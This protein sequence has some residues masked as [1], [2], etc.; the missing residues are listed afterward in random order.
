MHYSHQL[1]SLV[2]SHPSLLNPKQDGHTKDTGQDSEQGA[3]TSSDFE[4]IAFGFEASSLEAGQE[5]PWCVVWGCRLVSSLVRMPFSGSGPEDAEGF[6]GIISIISFWF[7]D[8]IP[9][10]LL[11]RFRVSHPLI[12][13]QGSFPARPPPPPPFRL[14]LGWRLSRM[15]HVLSGL[16][17]GLPNHHHPLG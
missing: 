17:F 7:A 12:S 13:C 16:G 9:I 5:A 1:S 10:H 3:W 11:L 14:P 8:R 4:S 15:S 6:P 2:P